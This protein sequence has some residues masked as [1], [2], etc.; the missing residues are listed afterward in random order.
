MFRN[1]G[2]GCLK[3]GGREG[4]SFAPA[5]CSFQLHGVLKYMMA[6]QLSI[7]VLLSLN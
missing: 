2:S 5:L 1:V 7:F 4:L 3:M 6:L